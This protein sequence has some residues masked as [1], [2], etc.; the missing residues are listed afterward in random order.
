MSILGIFGM[1]GRRERELRKLA[2]FLKTMPFCPAC[3]VESQ[4]HT[5][6]SISARWAGRELLRILDRPGWVTQ[7]L[8]PKQVPLPTPIQAPRIFHNTRVSPEEVITVELELKYKP[9]QLEIENGV[10]LVNGMYLMDTPVH[11]EIISNFMQQWADNQ[12][13]G[14]EPA[15]EANDVHTR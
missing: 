12:A 2:K 6:E 10:P 7:N 15:K 14:R 11:R 9:T 13:S 3:Q 5:C 4:E 8:E 1:S